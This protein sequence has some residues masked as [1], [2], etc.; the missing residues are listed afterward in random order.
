MS[1]QPVVDRRILRTKEAIQNALIGLIEEKGFEA[2]TVA[3]ITT[4]ANINRGTF[5]LHYQDKYDLVEKTVA[6]IIRDFKEIVLQADPF[7]ISDF[8]DSV[9]P[10]PVIIAFFE[11][12]KDHAPLL[13]AVLGIKGNI[14]IQAQMKKAI[15]SNIFN[16]GFF[17]DIKVKN[18]LVPSEYLI[19]YVSSAHLG[20]I[21]T[22]LEKGCLETPK[23]MASILSR[24]LFR[25]PVAAIGIE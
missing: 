5:Y 9:E 1:I 18:F 20:V 22:W 17:A 6:E 12:L 4:R 2:L 24:L 19:S 25:G 10:L 15:E 7:K 8:Y 14:S 11:Y 3:E 13:H 16:V 21:Q 23:E